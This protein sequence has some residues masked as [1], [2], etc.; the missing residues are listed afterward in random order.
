MTQTKN[1]SINSRIACVDGVRVSFLDIKKGQKFQLF[2]PDGI[3]VGRM[4]FVACGDGYENDA[5]IEC[6]LVE[7]E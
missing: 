6:I 1:H 5:G 3:P 4:D 7:G 2:E